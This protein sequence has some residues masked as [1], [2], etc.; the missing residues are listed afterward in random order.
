MPFCIS[1]LHTA[2]HSLISFSIFLGNL[3]LTGTLPNEIKHLQDLETLHLNDNIQLEGE[4]PSDAL[5]NLTS[6]TELWIQNTSLTG[7]INFLC[8]NCE[9]GECDFRADESINC[10][11]CT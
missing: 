3:R 5:A 7:D 8:S 1:I 10:D 2:Q 11:C 6:L 9:G 4:V